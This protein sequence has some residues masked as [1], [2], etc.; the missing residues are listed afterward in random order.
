MAT[1]LGREARRVL[2]LALLVS[3][4]PP[5]SPS[6]VKKLHHLGQEC[7]VIWLYQ[8]ERSTLLALLGMPGGAVGYLWNADALSL[9]AW[10]RSRIQLAQGTTSAWRDPPPVTASQ[11][12][13]LQGQRCAMAT[14]E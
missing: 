3:R 13:H 5:R 2:R 12:S 4:V 6:L 7:G 9:S 10:R 14:A 11:S 1:A 8:R